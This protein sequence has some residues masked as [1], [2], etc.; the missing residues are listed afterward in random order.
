MFCIILKEFKNFLIKK[1]K[2]NNFSC[3]LWKRFVCHMYISSVH[4]QLILGGPMYYNFL[5][6][7]GKRLVCL[8]HISLVHMQLILAGPMYFWS[9]CRTGF[10]WS[11]V[12]QKTFFCWSRL[13]KERNKQKNLLRV[14]STSY[15][16][17]PNSFNFDT[18]VDISAIYKGFNTF[19]MGRQ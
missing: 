14:L 15:C 10:W 4:M 18:Q 17:L 1:R 3:N 11:Y 16:F 9:T 5:Y 19:S 7:L 6:N 8:M 13:K 2:T 12:L